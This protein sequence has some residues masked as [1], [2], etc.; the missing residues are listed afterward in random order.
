LTS[1]AW[2]D[3]LLSLLRVMVGHHEGGNMLKSCLAT[4][5]FVL[6]FCATA[7]A[8]SVVFDLTSVEVLQTNPNGTIGFINLGDNPG[9]LLAPTSIDPVSGSRFLNVTFNLTPFN[10][11]WFGFVRY[12]W[13]LNGVASTTFNLNCQNGCSP[14]LS[15]GAGSFLEFSTPFFTPVPGSLTISVINNEGVTLGSGDYTFRIAE[16]VPEPATVM[17]LTTA[18]GGLLAVRKRIRLR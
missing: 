14:F 10:E 7:K 4:L 15:T 5:L 11:P 6:F 2:A 17:L 9:V 16:P 12:D 3:I 1:S 13:T 18:L 8:D